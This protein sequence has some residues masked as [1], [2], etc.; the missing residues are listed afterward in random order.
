VKVAEHPNLPRRGLLGLMFAGISVSGMLGGLIGYGLVAVSCADTPTRA[1]RMLEAV[2][3][4]HAHVASCAVPELLAA[5]A[6]TLITG[7]G[8]AVVAIL[9]LRAQSEWRGHA[10]RRR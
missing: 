4:F 7:I 5:L 1:E 6:G 2:P 3:G 10:P 8:A 9:M